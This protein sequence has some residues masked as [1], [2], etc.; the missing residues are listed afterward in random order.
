MP[1]MMAGSVKPITQLLK[2]VAPFVERQ[3]EPSPSRPLSRA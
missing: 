3:G 1:E 2:D